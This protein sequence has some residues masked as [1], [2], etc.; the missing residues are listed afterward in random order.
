MTLATI[1]P[2][3]VAEQTTADLLDDAAG[4]LAPLFEIARYACPALTEDELALAW[5]DLCEA[6]RVRDGLASGYITWAEVQPDLTCSGRQ[7]EALQMA[8][9]EADEARDR[10]QHGYIRGDAR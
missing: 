1:T 4:R 7:E 2:L 9:A 3:P 8:C 10:L 6:V 5:E